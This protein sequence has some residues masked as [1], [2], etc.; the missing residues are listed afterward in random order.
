MLLLVRNG[1]VSGDMVVC[2]GRLRATRIE[3]SS[4]TPLQYP[5]LAAVVPKGGLEGS[6]VA[7]PNRRNFG[8]IV[9]PRP[10]SGLAATRRALVVPGAPIV[11]VKMIRSCRCTGARSCFRMRK[12]S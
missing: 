1:H 12:I 6:C 11:S 5:P 9:I 7:Y 8:C 10:S 2:V 3:L 4:R